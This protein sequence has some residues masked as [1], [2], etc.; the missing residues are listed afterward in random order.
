MVPYLLYQGI[1]AAL[2]DDMDDRIKDQ[3][4]RVWQERIWPTSHQA[5]AQWVQGLFDSV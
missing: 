4:G 2:P 3:I 1:M 5:V